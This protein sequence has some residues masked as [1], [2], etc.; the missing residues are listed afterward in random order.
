MTVMRD[1]H[2]PW[3]KR[4]ALKDTDAGDLTDAAVSM[5]FDFRKHPGTDNPALDGLLRIAMMYVT[6]ADKA[7]VQLD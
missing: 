6:D 4:Q 3:C 7:A 2:F 1:E 5:A